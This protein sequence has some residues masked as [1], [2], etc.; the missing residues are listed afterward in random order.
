MYS[1]CTTVNVFQLRP[2]VNVLKF[3]TPKCLTKWHIQTVQTQI[4][5]YT[6]CHFTKYLKKSCI[7]SKIYTQKNE[8]IKTFRTFTVIGDVED[9]DD[10]MFYI[11][12]SHMKG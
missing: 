5:V 4:R 8:W 10:R 1:T 6:V 11:L 12:Y 2:T 7:L 9:D 3:C